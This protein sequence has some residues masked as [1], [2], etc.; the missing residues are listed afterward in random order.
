[1]RAP[2]SASSLPPEPPKPAPSPKTWTLLDNIRD[3]IRYL[4]G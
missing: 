1:M 3:I 2:K 4:S